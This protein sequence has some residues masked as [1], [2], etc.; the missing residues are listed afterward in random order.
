MVIPGWASTANVPGD[1]GGSAPRMSPKHSPW[2]PHPPPPAP[3]EPGSPLGSHCHPPQSP[4]QSTPHGVPGHLAAGDTGTYPGVH[5]P[6]CSD[7]PRGSPARDPHFVPW[8]PVDAGLLFE[9]PRVLQPP[10]LGMAEALRDHGGF[11]GQGKPAPEGTPRVRLSLWGA[12]H[13]PAPPP[14]LGGPPPYPAP[15]AHPPLRPPSPP[16]PPPP[17]GGRGTPAVTSDVEDEGGAGEASALAP[18]PP[19]PPP[20]RLR[21]GRGRK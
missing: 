3:P 21:R 1:C 11:G 10:P 9:A 12:P 15:P 16:A 18:P 20:S 17:T 8:P 13:I 19:L 2:C 7:A 5:R 14:H 4:A 6:P